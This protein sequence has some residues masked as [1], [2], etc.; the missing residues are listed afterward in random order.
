MKTLL[1]RRRLDANVSE[2]ECRKDHFDCRDSEQEDRRAISWLWTE[3]S[4]R[5]TSHS[6]G[7][8]STTCCMD[9]QATEFYSRTRGPIDHDHG[10][11]PGNDRSRIIL[12]SQRI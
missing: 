9:R 2:P 5:R 4:L 11:W 8:I 10:C 1:R 12:A 6:G 7:P 3:T